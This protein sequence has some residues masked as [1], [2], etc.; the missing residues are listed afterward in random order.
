M[1]RT[2]QSLMVHARPLV[3]LV[4]VLQGSSAVFGFSHVSRSALEFALR[5]RVGPATHA[6]GL[7]EQLTSSF[8]S[9]REHVAQ[10][11]VQRRHQ[12]AG[13]AGSACSP[14]VEP[15]SGMITRPIW[16]SRRMMRA[17]ISIHSILVAM[18]DQTAKRIWRWWLEARISVAPGGSGVQDLDKNDGRDKRATLIR[19]RGR[20]SG[21]ALYLPPILH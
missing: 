10:L 18:R 9:A 3:V 19:Q 15:N 6:P 20:P 1:S 12:C 5:Q 2:G 11:S 16:S 4:H 21:V 8:P 14:P 17:M 13:G 7:V